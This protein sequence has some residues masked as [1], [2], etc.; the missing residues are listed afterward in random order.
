M[1]KLKRFIDIYVPVEACTLR[2]HY[3]YITHHRLFA[4]KLPKFKYDVETFRKALSK[5]RLGGTCL[6]N[7]CG[8]GETLLPPE[9]PQYIRAVLEEGHY[10]MIVTNATVSRAFDAISQFPKEL[11][12]R[13]FFKFSYHYLQLKEKNLFNTFFAN[14]RKVRDAGASFTLE[15]TPS[16]ELIPYIEEMQ[17]LAKKEV[18]AT[19]HITVARNERDMSKINILTKMSRE[20]YYKTWSIFD[21]KLFDY[22]FSIF[23]EKRTEFCHAG[24]WTTYLDMGTGILYQC[25]KS[26]YNQNIFDNVDK[27]IHFKPIGC[28]CLQPHCFNGHAWLA[29][30]AIP[31]LIAPTYAELRNRNC[32]DGT[33]WLQSKM[34]DFMSQKLFENN[35][36]YSDQQMKSIN[37]AMQLRKSL[38]HVKQLLYAIYRKM[39]KK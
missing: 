9:L 6:L 10:V 32:V 27:P 29:L 30:G 39:A 12:D 14:I 7:F 28:N 18:G 23:G 24:D 2:C 17:Q 19:C 22:K 36:E 38:Y 3:C 34:K 33:E 31:T 35:T 15:A 21:S 11:L 8:G 4:N 20:E 5:E 37:Q 1:D 13:L 25:Y 26:L 16:D